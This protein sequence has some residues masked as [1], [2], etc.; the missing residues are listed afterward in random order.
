MGRRGH[1]QTP[2][3]DQYGEVGGSQDRD[4]PPLGK[5]SM[6]AGSGGGT[7]GRTSVKGSVSYQRQLP[8]FLQKHAHL[9]GKPPAEVEAVAEPDELPEDDDVHDVVCPHHQCNT[10]CHWCTCTC[11]Q[12]AIARAMAEDPTLLTQYPELQATADKARAA[13][14]KERGNAAFNAGK[15]DQAIDHYST[16]IQLDPTC[17]LYGG[18]QRGNINNVANPIRNEV[19]FSNRAAAYQ[20]AKRYTEALQDARAAVRLKP[21]WAKGYQRLAAAAWALDD[22]SEVCDDDAALC[23][24]WCKW[25]NRQYWR[26]KKR[27]SCNRAARSCSCC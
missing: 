8:K 25:A 6:G 24:I 9:L 18:Q 7:A 19:Y 22:V 13:E 11:A 2:Y 3:S 15:H 5:Q 14:E 1:Q 21:S 17:V 4:M 27:W 10:R 16:A 20:A 23:T 26:M 12:A